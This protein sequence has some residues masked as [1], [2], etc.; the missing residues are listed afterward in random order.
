MQT[1]LS[2]GKGTKNG[3][4]SVLFTPGETIIVYHFSYISLGYRKKSHPVTL[5]MDD[6]NTVCFLW[7]PTQAGKSSFG[8]LAEEDNA[9]TVYL[10]IMRHLLSVH[11]EIMGREGRWILQQ[12]HEIMRGSVV[13]NLTLASPL[14]S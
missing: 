2:P 5:Q 7:R 9:N 11:M 14:A 12:P 10:N 6:G 4:K 8:K 13:E 3:P 1:H